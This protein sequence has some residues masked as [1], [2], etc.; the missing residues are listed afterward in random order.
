MNGFA[1]AQAAFEAPP[2]ACPDAIT[3]PDCEGAGE[4]VDG[5]DRDV[6]DN[7]VGTGEIDPRDHPSW[8]DRCGMSGACP[9]CDPPGP[10]EDR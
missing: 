4:L 2:D 9:D 3:C 5:A 1:S 7:C 6:C 10:G 8:C